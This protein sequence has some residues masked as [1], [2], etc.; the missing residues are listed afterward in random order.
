LEIFYVLACVKQ[1]LLKSKTC[2]YEH[3]PFATQ[4]ANIVT[5]YQLMITITKES[6]KTVL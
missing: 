1:R 6:F 5:F 4:T 3:V 2:L